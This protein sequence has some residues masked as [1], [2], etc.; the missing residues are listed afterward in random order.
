MTSAQRQYKVSEDRYLFGQSRHKEFVP[1]TVNFDTADFTDEPLAF[2][3]QFIINARRPFISY[4]Q[5]VQLSTEDI[6]DD[7]RPAEAYFSTANDMECAKWLTKQRQWESG[8]YK[9]PLVLRKREGCR[10]S[11]PNP[12]ESVALEEQLEIE[13]RIQSG[14]LMPQWHSDEDAELMTAM[15]HKDLEF[16]KQ[17]RSMFL[18]R[19]DGNSAMAEEK[20]R[21]PGTFYAETSIGKICLPY[22]VVSES[23]A[24][25]Y[26]LR[27][28]PDTMVDLLRPETATQASEVTE[29]EID[30][31]TL[32]SWTPPFRAHEQM[33]ARRRELEDRCFELFLK[34]CLC[35]EVQV[36][37]CAFGTCG[38]M[39]VCDDCAR[40]GGRRVASWQGEVV[41]FKCPLCLAVSTWLRAPFN[42]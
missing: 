32:A 33:E 27:N 19:P 22:G 23:A 4:S 29:S 5:N 18:P 6:Y 10:M 36:I 35:C 41:F 17:A 7:R 13:R 15:F 16:V 34:Y 14:E 37:R 38:H 12:A 39:T 20:L 25:E 2:V 42:S 24:G 1:S 31:I 30:T 28:V 8:E 26:S 11:L 40:L 3:E 21:V 9:G